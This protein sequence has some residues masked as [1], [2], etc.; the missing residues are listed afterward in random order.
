VTLPPRGSATPPEETIAV[1]TALILDRPLCLECI[2]TKS[3]VSAAEAEPVLQR[4]GTAL[5]LY[6]E[7]ARCRMCD[8]VGRVVSVDRPTDTRL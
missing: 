4:I 3:G 5:K 2:S 1:L 6:R 8:A 7:V